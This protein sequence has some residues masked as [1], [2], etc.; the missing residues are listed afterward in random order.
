MTLSAPTTFDR[1]LELTVLLGRDMSSAFEGTGLTTARTHLLWVLHG[2]G[3]STQATL[4]HALEVT[5]R[6]ISGLVD[7]LEASGYVTRSAH[8]SDRRATI[9]TLSEAGEKTMQQMADDHRRINAVVTAALSDPERFGDDLA[10]VNAALS[11]LID[12]ASAHASMEPTAADSG[13][14]PDAGSTS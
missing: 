5:P 13:P 10:A 8:P 3:P 9:V 7:A 1:L 6:N 4:A 12:E 14:D 11:T 2:L